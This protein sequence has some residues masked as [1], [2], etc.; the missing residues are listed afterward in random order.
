MI[1]I[2]HAF[3]L[4]IYKVAFLVSIS[5]SSSLHHQQGLNIVLGLDELDSC[6]NISEPL[7]VV[8]DMVAMI[9]SIEMNGKENV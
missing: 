3:A 8:T 1:E 2:W 4:G 6:W 5:P 9:L 7:D